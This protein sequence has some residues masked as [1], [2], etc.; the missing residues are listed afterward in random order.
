LQSPAYRTTV[1]A[2]VFLFVG[3]GVAENLANYIYTYFWGFTPQQ[4][5][6]FILV[7]V[8][9]SLGV[10]STARQ[11]SARFGKRNVGMAC[12][13]IHATAFPSLI[14]LKLGGF[15]PPPGSA[16]L[17]IMI[18]VAA[19]VG[20]SAIIMGMTMIGSMIADITDEHELRTGAR[21]EGLLYSANMLL[22]KAASGL[23]VFCASIVIKIAS[24][25][26]GA[27]R[28]S[29][30]LQIINSLGLLSMGIA[31]VFGLGMAWSFSRY[32]LSRERHVEIVVELEKSRTLRGTIQASSA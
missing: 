28:D 10:L 31:V 7:V 3:F 27:S 25:P 17:L 9:A 30:P 21:Q 29:V 23:G 6:G 1:I 11:L 5:F 16:A 24:I 20:Y 19:Y 18:G 4:I 14:L 13:F 12:G 32:R 26:A 15:L 22:D 2:G 8:V